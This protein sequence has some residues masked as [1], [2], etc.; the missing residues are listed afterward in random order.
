MYMVHCIWY[1][2]HCV[3]LPLAQWVSLTEALCRCS[4]SSVLVNEF[5]PEQTFSKEVDDK[6]NAYFQVLY[7]VT[8]LMIYSNTADDKQ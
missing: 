7:T 8:Q 2:V 1:M 4:I 3:S 6:A 5:G